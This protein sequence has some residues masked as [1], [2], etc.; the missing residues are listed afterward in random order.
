MGVAGS[1][2]INGP[3]KETIAIKLKEVYEANKD[4]VPDDELQTILTNEYKRIVEA[5]LKDNGEVQSSPISVTQSQ[6]IDASEV[7]VPPKKSLNPA[8]G[9]GSKSKQSY[10]RR[11]SFDNP[12]NAKK[13]TNA[14]NSV[15]RNSFSSPPPAKTVSQDS[16]LSPNTVSPING[17]A[18]AIKK[19]N[20]LTSEIMQSKSASTLNISE[21]SIATDN[22]DSVTQQPY[23]DIC[24][25]AFKSLTF[26]DR[27]LKYS[28]LHQDNEKR[29]NEFKL[30]QAALALSSQADKENEETHNGAQ[31][32]LLSPLPKGKVTKDNLLKK[33][34]QEEGVHYRMLYSGNKFF[35][36]Y[37]QSIDIDMYHHFLANTVEIIPYYPLK[38]IE[39]PRIYI[40]Y[41][42]LLKQNEKIINEE[43][44]N[45]KKTIVKENKFH[46]IIDETKLREEIAL[47]KLVT[48]LLQRISFEP[49]VTNVSDANDRDKCTFMQLFGDEV[50]ASPVVDKMPSI[51]I[52]IHLSRRRR[53][54]AEEIA[55]TME[56]LDHD[57]MVINANLQKAT[58]F[59]EQNDKAER[60]ANVVYSAV[61]ILYEK[62][63]QRYLF[64]DNIMKHPPN[65]KSLKYRY[66][67]KKS[68]S[69]TI[70][71]IEVQKTKE[72]LQEKGFALT[73]LP[74]TVDHMINS[75][76]QQAITAL[77]ND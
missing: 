74:T 42:M 19:L 9:L 75:T 63:Q 58:H 26:L 28:N 49:F 59:A 30:Q 62:L 24:K 10:S 54:T 29:L 47:I 13:S 17:E 32:M 6:S 11:R 35:W 23:C 16:E 64:Q 36:R 8:K 52:P 53:S 55:Q 66:L 69:C 7:S 33:V 65:E 25:M 2:S 68:I 76:T 37:Q 50:Y 51:L 20:A 21:D 77:R 39:L 4:L 40:S 15:A 48:F 43:L 70:L 38:H 34:I 46:S 60:I 71:Q 41:D 22:W 12:I 61:T 5:S 1:V 45:K 44:A 18:S 56:R 67:W 31:P 14:S 57:H 3:E 72:Y 27:H 73:T